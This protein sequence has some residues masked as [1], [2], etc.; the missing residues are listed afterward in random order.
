[1]EPTITTDIVVAYSQCPRKAYLLL[2]S[3][4]KGEPHEY[5]QILEQQR[6]ENQERYLN[7]LQR[8]HA[9]VQPYSVENFRKGSKVLINV[10]LQVDGFAADCGVLT[11]VEGTST[12]GKYSYEPTL[13]VGTH[14][15]SKEQQLELSFVGYVLE[16]LQHKSPAVGRII[17]MDGKS[18]TVKLGASSKALRPLLEPLYEWITV[19]APKP[20]A[21]VLNKHCPLCPFQRVCQ[22]QAEQEDNLSLLH[23][24]TAR[25]MRQYERKGIFTVQQLSYLF[26][27]RKRKKGN[28]KSPPVTHK[29]ELQ[30]LAIREQKIYLQELPAL[31]RQ[32]VELFVDMEGVPDKGLYYLIGVL[33]CQGDTTEHYSFWANTDQDERH[34]WQQ[35][36]DKVAQYLD[37]PIY[38][39]GSYEPRAIAT[40]AKRYQ[41]DCAHLLK[42]LVNVN[43]LIYG[44]IYFPVRSNRLKDIGNFIGAQWTSSQASGLQS[45]VWR[46]QWEAT[47]EHEYKEVLLT[48]NTEDCRALLAL[49]SF[50]TTLRDSAYTLMNVDFADRPKQHATQRGED[51]HR[52]FDLI[53]QSA[54]TDYTHKRVRLRAEQDPA[55]QLPKKRGAQHGHQG[56]QR[57]LPTRI[58]RVIQVPPRST[59]PTHPD[60]LLQD[61]ESIAEHPLIDLHFTSQGCRKTVTMYRGALGYCP[62]CEKSYAPQ[63]IEQLG[64]Q[65]FGHGLQAWV[66]Y[67]RMIL[68]LPYRIIIQVME[69]MFGERA[70]L[71]TILTFFTRFA[72]YYVPTERLLLQQL[73]RSPFLHVD[74]TKLSIQGTDQYV[75]GFT[76]GKHVVFKLTATRETTLVHE[77]LA[78]YEGVLV[79]DFYAGYD[80]VPCRQQKCLVHLIRDL[81]DDLWSN[82]WNSEFES[83]VFAVKGLLVPI[84]EAVETYGLKRRHLHKFHA[85]IDRFYQQHIVG[86]TYTSETTIKFQKRFQRYRETLFTF[87]H[88]DG[89]PWQNNTAERALRHIAVQRK[90]SGSFF[91]KST[92]HFLLLLGISQTCQFQDKSFLKFLLSKELDLDAFQSPKRVQT[93][94]PVSL[95]RSMEGQ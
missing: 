39:Y 84:F 2:F 30:A 62:T 82:P 21:L 11:R 25:V 13:F 12:F 56:Y 64:G 81:N 46:H 10:H 26:K 76:D 60:K 63:G 78:Q 1:M 28:R 43:S 15:I 74:E 32:P 7:R 92:H 66:I 95:H 59:C 50:L 68:R 52:V 88:E 42:R 33:V 36:L 80:A 85:A 40:L 90:I 53:L 93:S 38:H 83:F 4:D 44:K 31:S 47:R 51:I 19:D 16:R 70:S 45:L 87:L 5:V 67:Q 20:P 86:T 61:G 3:P 49:A 94:R 79:A 14:S 77:M 91:E 57:L 8:T 89:I 55:N 41:T 73:L 22:T 37:A 35:F 23:G 18:H 24:M 72:A 9:D 54:H 75:W 69:E 71:G 17:G 65:L 27:P 48:Y 6:C 34:M 29:V 58:G